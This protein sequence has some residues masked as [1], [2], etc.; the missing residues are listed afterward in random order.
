MDPYRLPRTIVPSRY[1]L[2]LEPDLANATFAG[3][4]EIAM[5]VHEAV[6]EIVLNAAE[7]HIAEASIENSA[8]NRSTAVVTL[9]EETERCRLRF[10][11][12]L[13][14]GEWRL[15]ADI[16]RRTE[17]QA[18]RLLPQF[19]QESSRRD[20]HPRGHAVRGDRRP[21]RLPLLGRACIQSR[22]L[23]DTGCSAGIASR[24][25]YGHRRGAHR[26]R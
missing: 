2:R 25:Q 19:V 12:P 5:T 1:D 3:R 8:V 9:E 4:V 18:A 11:Q 6:K 21:P 23:L 26:E 17:R 15:T 16:Q 7:L 20:A 13:T 10:G 14:P 24:L 22:L